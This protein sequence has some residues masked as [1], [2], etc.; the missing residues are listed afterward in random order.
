MLGQAQAVPGVASQ[1]RALVGVVGVRNY[2]KAQIDVFV[3]RDARRVQL[4]A[5]ARAVAALCYS[6]MKGVGAQLALRLRQRSQ[7]LW[8]AGCPSCFL[9]DLP[10]PRPTEPDGSLPAVFV[11]RAS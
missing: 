11:L 9:C 10:P 7:A 3:R 4:E 2:D 1:P 8:R 5:A 6:A